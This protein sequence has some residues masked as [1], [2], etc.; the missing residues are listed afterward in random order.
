MKGDPPED[1]I[2]GST[3]YPVMAHPALETEM[4]VGQGMVS[5]LVGLETGQGVVA[6]AAR[7]GTA[8]SSFS[9]KSSR[10]PLLNRLSRIRRRFLLTNARH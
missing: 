10:F 6:S 3:V 9:N 4:A 7:C 5:A 8:L 2:N 1:L